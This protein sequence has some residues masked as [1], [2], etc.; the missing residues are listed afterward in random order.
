MVNNNI[1]K[2]NNIK[3]QISNL[4]FHYG[5][6]QVLKNINFDMESNVVT[7]IIGRFG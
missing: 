7:A 5:T 1:K 3:M 4:N 6:S 2:Q